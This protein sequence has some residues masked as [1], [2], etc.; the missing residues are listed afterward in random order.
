MNKSDLY[1][2]LKIVAKVLIASNSFESVNF[3]IPMLYD[4]ARSHYNTVLLSNSSIIL[5]FWYMRPQSPDY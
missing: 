3:D 5:N 4:A 2:D 1:K